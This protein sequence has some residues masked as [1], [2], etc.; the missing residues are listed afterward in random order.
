MKTSTEYC[1]HIDNS[2]YHRIYSYNYV[3]CI[4]YFPDSSIKA[5]VPLMLPIS[6]PT[7]RPD[8]PPPYRVRDRCNRPRGRQS[9]PGLKRMRTRF[10]L[11]QNHDLNFPPIMTTADM[12]IGVYIS[13]CILVSSHMVCNVP[14]NY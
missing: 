7:C 9:G 12:T 10:A 1:V 8:S 14:I 4:W 13:F 11:N 5:K 3:R 6:Y 2:E